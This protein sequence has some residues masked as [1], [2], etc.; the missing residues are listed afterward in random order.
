[1]QL[2]DHQ[3]NW[4]ADH[5]TKHIEAAYESLT[6]EAKELPRPKLIAMIIFIATFQTAAVVGKQKSLRPLV[7]EVFNMLLEFNINLYDAIDQMIDDNE[8]KQQENSH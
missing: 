4:L 5:Y 1:M 7:Q 6:A 3:F 2:L 8:R